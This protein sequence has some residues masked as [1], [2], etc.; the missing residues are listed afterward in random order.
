MNDLVFFFY[1]FAKYHAFLYLIIGIFL[2]IMTIVL[3]Y[4]INVYCM[5]A[6]NKAD[7]YKTTD[8]K[9]NL[10]RGLYEQTSRF[11]QKILNNRK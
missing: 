10:F 3:L 2:L 1:F 11:V 7:V 4:F 8:S 6:I 9:L 5:F